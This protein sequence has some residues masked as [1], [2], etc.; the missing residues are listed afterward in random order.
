MDRQ[1][2]IG[3]VLPR[4]ARWCVR[5]RRLVVFG[6]WIPALIILLG[7]SGAVGTD[8]HTQFQLPSGEA[9]D[10]FRQLEAVSKEA[11]G[12][13]AQIVVEAPKGVTDEELQRE[14]VPF[15]AAVDQLAGVQVTSP[16]DNPQ[17]ISKDGTIGY[18]RL[19]VTE[20]PQEKFIT[21]ADD[22]KRLGGKLPTTTPDGSTLRLEYGGSIFG[23]FTFPPSEALGVVAAVVILVLAFGSI[24]AMGLPIGTALFGLGLGT[25]IV[26]LLSHIQEMPDFTAQMVAMIGLGVG[27]DY[28]LFIVTRYREG[29]HAGLSVEEAVVE[30]VDTSGRA[31]LF[32]GITVIISLLG[33]FI[34]G[35]SFVRGL[36]TGAAVGV[37][38]MMIASL[39]LLPALLA[40]TGDRIDRT[41]RAALIAL[42]AAV[43][44]A[45]AAI[46]TKNAAALG[47]GVL[48]AAIVLVA[49]IFVK[50]L[51]TPL[52]HRRQKPREEGLW[53][54]WSRIVQHR[55]WPILG[56][57]VVVLAALTIPLFSI[58]L[59][60]ADNGNVQ[61]K[62]TA[63]RAYD[64]LAKGFGPGSNGP[65]LVTIAGPAASDKAT[66]D[67]F[68]QRLQATPGVVAAFT[69]PEPIKPDLAVFTIIPS[70][71]P[72]DEATSQ[73]VTRL[74]DEVVPASGLNARVG[75]FTAA[76]RDFADYLGSRLP[77]LIGAVLVLSFLLLMAVFRSL[78]VPLK[79]VV[80]NLLSIGAAYGVI[81]A[82]FQWGWAKNVFGIE[83]GP[84][85]AW[86][87]MMLFAI[88]FGLSMD[89]EV[90][91]LSRMKEEFDR[92]GDNASAVADGLAVTARVITAA[93]LIMVCVFSAF[94]LGDNRQLKLFGL[95]LAAAVAIDATI[96]RMLL[97]PATMELLGARNWWLPK[98]MDR[99]LPQIDVEGHHHVAA[100]A[101]STSIDSLQGTE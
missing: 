31:V 6:L 23:R 8:F 17:Q 39:T 98:W 94:V 86:V 11:A 84:I 46:I 44:G 49:G 45:L 29:L 77:V 65:L 20:R 7:V 60:F 16:Y 27:I 43:A 72:Q 66:R 96:V 68:V 41:S 89:Y 87:P 22:I 81:V 79:A 36:A 54:R 38:L 48:L 61:E 28:A 91:L 90:F 24:I 99:V 58:R 75:G 80:M 52:P 55:P 57:A 56:V 59:G 83:K 93:A 5:R 3:R 21:L 25:S 85:E 47:V 70:S 13:D 4:L 63:R 9:K 37:L 1:S 69:A 71:A 51:R 18:A 67:A 82:V 26:T 14:L 64:L 12:F 92:T 53:Y 35:L 19:Q 40:M 76:S 2:T 88:V 78:L 97:V 33:L 100:V 101:G 42:T 95:G 74:R 50:S 15:F 32:A 73:L 30:S 10:V 34:M 62:Q